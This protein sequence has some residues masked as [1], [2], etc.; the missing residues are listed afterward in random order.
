MSSRPTR[1]ARLGGHTVK[2]LVHAVTGLQS[3]APA[4]AGVH[5]GA[6][7]PGGAQKV[8]FNCSGSSPPPAARVTPTRFAMVVEHAFPLTPGGKQFWPRTAAYR[9][10]CLTAYASV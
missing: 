7:P 10:P 9:V 3:T 1:F 5:V 8:R 2:L 6:T 4:V